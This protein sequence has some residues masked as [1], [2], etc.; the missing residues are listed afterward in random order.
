MPGEA[1]PS[2]QRRPAFIC[3]QSRIKIE[4]R[5]SRGRKEGREQVGSPGNP[6]LSVC[7]ETPTV[8]LPVHSRAAASRERGQSQ[9]QSRGQTRSSAEQR[10]S[11]GESG[12]AAIRRRIPALTGSALLCPAFG[13]GCGSG[14]GCFSLRVRRDF[15]PSA[16]SLYTSL[17]PRTQPLAPGLD[18]DSRPLA[19]AR[20]P[21]S[22]REQATG[23][24]G[25][26]GR[27]GQ[28]LGAAE[29]GQWRGEGAVA[30]QGLES[31]RWVSRSSDGSVRPVADPVGQGRVGPGRC[32]ASG[33]QRAGERRGGPVGWERERLLPADSGV[34]AH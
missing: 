13:S 34:G 10:Q 1:E 25:R 11:A 22:A 6:L 2:S 30:G 20:R 7:H 23:E 3:S 8:R 24:L 17:A 15:A 16:R 33:G 27:V 19:T 12:P 14:C 26:R 21:L 18:T 4:I 28:W 31:S 5:P 9:G 32:G 29:G